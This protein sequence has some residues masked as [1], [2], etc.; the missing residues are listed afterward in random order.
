[1]EPNNNLNTVEEK[2][3]SPVQETKMKKFLKDGLEFLKF[4]L[5]ALAIVVP[6]RMF[7]AQPFIVSGASMMPTFQDKDYLIIDEISYILGD[8]HRY[9]VIVF[10]FPVETSKY[11]IKRVIGLP[12]ETVE[13]TNGK[14]TIF[15]KDAVS[16]SA[17]ITIN[18]P[19]INEPFNTTKTIELKDGEYFVMGDNR[20]RSSDSRS[21]GVLPRKD[22]VGRAFLRLLPAAHA[23]YLPG[24]FKE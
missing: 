21:W 9:D 12:G 5:I 16:D 10:K 17:G 23:D 8:P 3:E 7:I 24:A 14:V 13:I 11:L 1:M 19:Y 4:A 20:N 22:I 2:Q 15:K 6:I 18:E